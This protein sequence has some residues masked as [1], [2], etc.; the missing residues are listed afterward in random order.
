M[1]AFVYDKG[2]ALYSKQCISECLKNLEI[3]KNKKKASIKAFQALDTEVQIRVF[4]FWNC[5]T[6]L[7]IFK[8]LDASSLT[9]ASSGCRLRGATAPTGGL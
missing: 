4:T 3:T 9:S 8:V 5:P 7:G 2:G 6:P 1:A